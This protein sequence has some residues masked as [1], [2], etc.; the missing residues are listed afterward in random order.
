[1]GGWEGGRVGGKM[2]PIFSFMLK[3]IYTLN[4]PKFVCNFSTLLNLNFD[5]VQ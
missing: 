1:M 2:Y 3:N 4:L 5:I